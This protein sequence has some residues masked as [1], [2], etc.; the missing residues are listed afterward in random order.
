MALTSDKEGKVVRIAGF[1]QDNAGE[2]VVDEITGLPNLVPL[3]DRLTHSIKTTGTH[4]GSHFAVLMMDLELPENEHDQPESEDRDLFLATTA[5]RLETWFMSARTESPSGRDHLVAR[6]EGEG[7]IILINGLAEVNESKTI[8]VQLLKEISIP[9]Q[10]KGRKVHISANIGI[11]LGITGYLTAQDALRDAGTALYRSKLLGK[12]HCEVFDT[13]VLKS[14][15]A[16]RVSESDLQEAITRKEFSVFYQP[17]I[18]LSSRHIAG[19]EA[20]LRWEHPVL[21]ILYPGEFIPVAEKTGLIIPLGR[22]VIHEA[23][24]QLKAW[25]DNPQVPADLWVSVNLSSAQFKHASLVEDIRRI[26]SEVGNDANGLVI[27][28]TEGLVIED[29]EAANRV[30]MQLRAMGVRIALDDFGTGYSSLAHLCRFP[31][32]YLKIDQS[33]VR[34]IETSKDEMEVIRT[35]NS[36][37][38]QFGLRVI[39]EGIENPGQR[40]IVSSLKCDYGQ[41]FLFSKAVS[42]DKVESLLKKEFVSSGVNR[43][44]KKA[45]GESDVDHAIPHSEKSVPQRVHPGLPQS[46]TKKT[47]R[48]LRANYALII[49][50]CATVML[51]STTGILESIKSSVPAVPVNEKQLSA[52]EK[53]ETKPPPEPP[54][55]SKITKPSPVYEFEVIHDHLLGSCRGTLKISKNTV[56]YISDHEKCNFSLNYDEIDSSLVDGRLEIKTESQNYHFETENTSE[57]KED[58]SKIQEIYKRISQFKPSN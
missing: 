37:A 27:E 42:K 52:P 50:G 43:R 20:L 17:I 32:D 41:G 47:K 57:G 21:G 22:W 1:H 6:P 2:K 23:C 7:F 53:A 26:F 35:I 33:F 14:I 13:A 49:I 56:S 28:L 9:I 31:L 24:R 29:P 58:H 15:K 38:F 19:F 12:N 4:G 3:L 25:E 5:R 16:D 39:A 45:K 36:L 48:L 10:V 34:N 11:A 46:G 51:F 30:L 40:D 18:S 44:T 8:A 54:K 55:P